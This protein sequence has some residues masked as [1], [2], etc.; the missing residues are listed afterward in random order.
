MGQVYFGGWV[1]FTSALTTTNKMRIDALLEQVKPA[2]KAGR[3]ELVRLAPGTVLTRDFMGQTH[4]VVAMSNGEFEYN[5]KPYS[6]LTAIACE[7]AG[8]RWSGP[9]FF[10]L[11]NGVKKQCKGAGA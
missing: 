10:G 3:G 5:G 2:Q 11:R 8:T 9:A 1:S 6:S 7:I 4:R